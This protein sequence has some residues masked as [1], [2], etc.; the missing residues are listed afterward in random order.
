MTAWRYFA[1]RII[2]TSLFSS[3]AAAGAR[4]GE[5]LWLGRPQPGQCCPEKISRTSRAA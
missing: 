1:G 3:M 4:I 2:A 5:L